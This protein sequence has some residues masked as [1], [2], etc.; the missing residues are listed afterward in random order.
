VFIS[1]LDDALLQYYQISAIP[2]PD[3]YNMKYLWKWLTDDDAGKY[4]IG[5]M[6]EQCTWGDI[7]Y[8][9]PK[10]HKS[11]L[12]KIVMALWRLVWPLPA[13]K[14]DLGLVVMEPPETVDRFT[15]WVAYDYLPL[16]QEFA[17][18]IKREYRRFKSKFK[19][20][21]MYNLP[22]F[23]YE[24]LL[25]RSQ[26]EEQENS[27]K[28]LV[29]KVGRYTNLGSTILACSLPVVAITVLSRLEGDRDLLL[30][31]AG[32]EVIFAFG[33]FWVTGG[34]IKKVDV[35]SATAV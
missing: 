13:P 25:T 3:P 15:Q 14:S 28:E 12:R 27:L 30:C 11:P 20:R 17:A 4:G 8:V 29:V 35:F 16:W 2:E 33:L 7:Y 6:G 5:G 19:R 9:P 24:D 21:T 26:K 34:A 31:I 32:F 22:F 1:I 10:H 23:A 18:F